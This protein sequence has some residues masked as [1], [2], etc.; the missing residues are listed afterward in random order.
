[1]FSYNGPHGGMTLPQ[2]PCCSVAYVLSLYCVVLATPPGGVRNIVMSMSACL[3][4]Y[5]FVCSHIS[6]TARLKFTNI[7]CLL[8][9]AVARS[10][11]DRVAMS[12]VL[13]V[14]RMTLFSYHRA[15]GSESS[16]TLC[17]EEFRQAAVP[18]GRQTTAAFG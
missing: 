15:N 6:K 18:V 5:L 2:Q 3:S 10:S 8:H 11:S 14:L 4:L 1:M 7:L 13:P 17:L 9:T 12:Y 16:A